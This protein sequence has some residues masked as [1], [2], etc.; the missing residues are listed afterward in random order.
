MKPLV[1]Q[2]LDE[3][4]KY[5]MYAKPSAVRLLTDYDR[6]LHDHGM[7]VAPSS[8]SIPINPTTEEEKL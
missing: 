4:H 2:F 3:Y 1:L 6:W 5:N 8:V 7:I